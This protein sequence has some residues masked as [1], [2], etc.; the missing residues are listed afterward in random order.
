MDKGLDQDLQGSIPAYAGETNYP[1]QLAP[2]EK[3]D[4]RVRGG[5]PLFRAT[6]AQDR[7]RSPRTRGRLQ[8]RAHVHRLPRSIPAYAGE[9]GTTRA[10][11]PWRWVDP[12]VRGG[13][14]HHLRGRRG[15]EGRSPRTRGRL[16]RTMRGLRRGRSIPAYAGETFAGD[17]RKAQD[18]VDPRVRGGDKS[19]PYSNGWMSGRSPR[20]RGR[21][22]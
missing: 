21:P 17:T 3:V 18:Q 10:G 11:C 13:D 4:P 22:P 6:I 19:I 15:F 14:V 16:R 20:T 9:T 8:P 2:R 5:D 12:R 7:G 1:P